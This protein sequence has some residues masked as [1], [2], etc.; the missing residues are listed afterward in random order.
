VVEAG[1]LLLILLSDLQLGAVH[2]LQLLERPLLKQLF[3]EVEVEV[4]LG[5]V[6]LITLRLEQILLLDLVF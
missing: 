4:E 6:G 5:V 1:G 2:T 3:A